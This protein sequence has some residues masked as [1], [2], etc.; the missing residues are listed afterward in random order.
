MIQS[1]KNIPVT[2]IWNIDSINSTLR[3]IDFYRY[4]DMYKN[5]ADINRLYQKVEELVNHIEKQ[6]EMGLNFLIG[7][8]PRNNA[9]SYDMYMNELILGDN[10]YMAEIDST[11][12]TFLNHSAIY[13]IGT[14]DVQFNEAMFGSLNNVIK[15]STH[16]SRSGEKERVRFFNRLRDK[17]HY[18]QSL[19]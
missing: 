10:T 8:E 17:I 12:L 7:T 15:K 3:Q 2:E 16:I 5:K 14:R 1:Y 4:S 9:P 13:F 19:L 18:K 11:R 6:A